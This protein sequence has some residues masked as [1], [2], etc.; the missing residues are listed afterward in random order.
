MIGKKVLEERPITSSEAKSILEKRGAK[1]ELNYEQ[2]TTVDYLAKL[3]K[4]NPTKAKK[5]VEELLKTEKI[6][7]EIAVKIVDLL[8]RDEE[9]VRAIFAKE[10]YVLTKEEIGEILK[11]I[12][13]VK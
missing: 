1:E 4:L 10:R 5:A 8:P 11:V 3:I 6:K 7:P 12:D 2:R 9:D 13:G